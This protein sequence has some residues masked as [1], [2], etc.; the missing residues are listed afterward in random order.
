MVATSY[1][2]P[3]IQP[4]LGQLA[5]LAVPPLLVLGFWCY[6]KPVFERFLVL[7]SVY[8]FLVCY[9]LWLGAYWFDDFQSHFGPQSF[10]T[11]WE[12]EWRIANHSG[13]K[14]MTPWFLGGSFVS[15]LITGIV[16]WAVVKRGRFPWDYDGCY[17]RPTAETH[18]PSQSATP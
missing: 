14:K 10:S 17:G 11:I 12:A 4:I 8:L 18:Q 9:G 1:L 15:G 16:W 6:R 3:S 2:Y 5:G 7:F 13:L